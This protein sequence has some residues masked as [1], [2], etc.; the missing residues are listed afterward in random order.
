MIIAAIYAHGISKY[1]AAAESGKFAFPV[2][3]YL[4][5]FSIIIE[6]STP[7][8]TVKIL[9]PIRLIKTPP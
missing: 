1:Q 2:L 8:G 5:I 4:I 3:F 9:F 7:S 6:T